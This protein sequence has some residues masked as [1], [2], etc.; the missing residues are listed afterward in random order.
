MTFHINLTLDQVLNLDMNFSRVHVVV[1]AST[2]LKPLAPPSFF[3][4]EL[5]WNTVLLELTQLGMCSEV[6]V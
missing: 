1:D 3:A 5:F 4:M 2:P 6:I